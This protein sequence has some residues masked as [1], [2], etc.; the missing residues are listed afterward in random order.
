[1]FFVFSIFICSKLLCLWTN[2]DNSYLFRKK[3][4]RWWSRFNLICLWPIISKIQ[5]WKFLKANRRFKLINILMMPIRD[6]ACQGT[7]DFG[8]RHIDGFMP[9]LDEACQRPAVFGLPRHTTEL[10]NVKSYKN[11]EWV[12]VVLDIFVTSVAW[13]VVTAGAITTDPSKSFIHSIV[14]SMKF[15]RKESDNLTFSISSF[16]RADQFKSFIIPVA[17]FTGPF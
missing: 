6:E 1:M 17:P 7:T 10:F 11:G 5:H 3:V 13:N 8:D 2:L 12:T 9:I 4:A 14:S 16:R 15:D